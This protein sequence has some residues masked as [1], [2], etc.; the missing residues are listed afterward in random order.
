MSLPNPDVA[1]A[2]VPVS[3]RFNDLPALRA[4]AEGLRRIRATVMQ[5]PEEIDGL[6]W[7]ERHCVFSPETTRTTDSAELYGYQRGIVS[8]MCD[9]INDIVVVSKATRTGVTQCAA[10]ATAYYIAHK[11]TQ[12]AFVQPTESKSKDFEKSYIE[13]MLRDVKPL[14]AIRRTVRKGDIQDTWSLKFF[15]NGSVFRCF[16]AEAADNFRSYTGQVNIGDEV[17]ADGWMSNTTKAQG[18]KEKLF[19]ERSRT[20]PIRKTIFM[21]S[22]RRRGTCR[23]TALLEQ[24]DRRRYFVP[25]PHC[26][27]MQ[28]LQLG[29]AK[30]DYGMKWTLDDAGHVLD[31]KYQCEHCH[32]LIDESCKHDMDRN[33]EW[34]AT[35]IPKRPGVAGFVVTAFM[36]RFMGA[37]WK[38]LIQEWLS[39]QAN[40][41]ELETVVNNILAEPWDEVGGVTVEPEGLAARA[42]DLPAEVPDWVGLLTCG[43]DNQTG[44]TDQSKVESRPPRSEAQVVG[45]GPEGRF[46]PIAYLVFDKHTPFSPEANVE[47]DEFRRRLWMKRDGSTLKIE[48]TCIDMGG[49]NSDG[50][51]Y[52]DDVRAY[53]N[54]RSRRGE[55]CWAIKGNNTR[56]NK[57]R[58]S[59]KPVWPRK[60][61]RKT[62]TGQWFQVETQRAKFKIDYLQKLTIAGGGF[63]FQIPRSLVNT[64]GYLDSLTAESIHGNKRGDRWFAPKGRNTG[65]AWDTLVYAYI[66]R[67]GLQATYKKWAD[68]NLALRDAGIKSTGEV[69]VGDDRSFNSPR[70]QAEL[71]YSPL[72]DATDASNGAGEQMANNNIEQAKPKVV[73]RRQ[74]VARSSFVSRY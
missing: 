34:I 17:A 5:P 38:S 68:L 62:G 50:V 35:A 28:Y 36:S 60:A 20:F 10:F 32:E 3:R 7:I 31:V 4:F 12:V 2:D 30:T 53:C 56:L 58:S 70:R 45:W 6:T 65:E 33:G 74:P 48:A 21:S 14:K 8:A 69:Y 39:A 59:D 11:R 18:S 61:S 63:L 40:P 27:G 49:T 16:S 42:V 43:I 47:L 72:V 73:R 66:A 29:S 71:G 26:G 51:G 13:P 1:A 15:R 64:V 23:I 22:P 25:C 37:N 24:S 41:E 57:A 67:C 44:N 9:E 19:E 52:A 54:D 55:N 46:I